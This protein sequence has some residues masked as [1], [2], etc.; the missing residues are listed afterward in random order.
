M[1]TTETWERYSFIATVIGAAVTVAVLIVGIIQFSLTQN[2]QRKALDDE[3]EGR[4]IDLM[5]EYN[6]LMLATAK[7]EDDKRF[8]K[9]NAAISIADSMYYLRANDDDGWEGTVRWI[10]D[11][12]IDDLKEYKLDCKTT[13]DEYI[14]FVNET[15]GTDICADN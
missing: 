8:W 1:I 11:K 3:L 5:V 9:N 2:L 13:G 14:E 4:A 12:H 10:L 7:D 6:N 15:Y